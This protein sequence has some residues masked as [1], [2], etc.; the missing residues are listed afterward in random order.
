MTPGIHNVLCQVA[1][2]LEITDYQPKQAA[3]R[4]DEI[5]TTLKRIGWTVVD[6]QLM[7]SY[8]RRTIIRPL[9]ANNV[10]VMV[11]LDAGKYM[12]WQN[13]EGS[14]HI[15]GVIQEQLARSFK[16]IQVEQNGREIMLSF[17]EFRVDVIPAMRF[18]T[19]AYLIPEAGEDRWLY[20]D[21]VRLAER[22]ASANSRHEG[23]FIQLIKLVKLWNRN[24][25]S[26][27]EGF[28]IECM[29]LN[30]HAGVGRLGGV[31]HSLAPAVCD[32]F[33]ALP[34]LIETP[35]TDPIH[36]QRVDLYLTGKHGWLR[37]DEALEQAMDAA[38][39]AG[40]A[41]EM[42]YQEREAEAASYLGGL[43][44]M[45]LLV[46]SHAVSPL[47]QRLTQ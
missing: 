35:T 14:H 29:L 46:P 21:P 37:H 34:S 18:P 47:R 36:N 27:L 22:V 44:G 31:I 38:G 39:R 32:F 3:K 16:R 1:T 2:D 23:N 5:V 6:H 40:A 42:L 30:R 13:P 10:D 24:A 45:P 41:L 12:R 25:G 19:G 28:H 20:S 8:V 11:E 9:G 17:P 7:G 26:P 33:L 4:I 43:L 15:V